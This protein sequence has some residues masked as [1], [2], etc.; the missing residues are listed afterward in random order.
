MTEKEK[1]LRK[2]IQRLEEVRDEESVR[3]NDRELELQGQIDELE[4][5]LQEMTKANVAS[6]QRV[7]ELTG[8][9]K[10]L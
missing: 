1:E 10:E 6:D 9:E 4:N 2:E 7:K 3:K 5:S 8:K